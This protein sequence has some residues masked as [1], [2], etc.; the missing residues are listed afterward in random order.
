MYS[1]K[2][3]KYKDFM[4]FVYITPKNNRNYTNVRVIIKK[5]QIIQK[6]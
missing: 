2:A 1:L 6:M 5:E 4:A 3:A